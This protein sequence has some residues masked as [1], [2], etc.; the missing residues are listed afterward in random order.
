MLS[1]VYLLVPHLCYN[2]HSHTYN[3]SNTIK[4]SLMRVEEMP[5]NR[6]NPKLLTCS[7]TLGR[8]NLIGDQKAWVPKF[9]PC[10]SSTHRFT[11]DP[12]LF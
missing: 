3:L 6:V 9:C 5:L 11:Y 10:V 7:G 12:K 1:N 4:L 2:S 8:A